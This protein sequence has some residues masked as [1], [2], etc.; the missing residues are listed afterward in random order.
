MEC[1][2]RSLPDRVIPGATRIDPPL[3]RMTIRGLR[4]VRV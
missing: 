3:I 2:N 4:A 1:I